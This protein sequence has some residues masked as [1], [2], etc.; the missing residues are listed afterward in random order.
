MQVRLAIRKS[1]LK[2][3]EVEMQSAGLGVRVSYEHEVGFQ[4]T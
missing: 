2:P 4:Q 3:A 1:W